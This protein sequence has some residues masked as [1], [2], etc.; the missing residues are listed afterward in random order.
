MPPTTEAR[1]GPA[2]VIAIGLDSADRRLVE[3]WC[4]SG[5]LPALQSMR[6][7][8]AYG[9]LTGFP[10]L[11]DDSTWASFYTSVSPGRHRRYFWQF[12]DEGAYDGRP[13]RY[14][15]LPVEPFWAVLSQ[16]GRR[17]AVLD[18]PKCPL[19]T[20]LNGIQIA[21]WLVHGRDYP[22]TCCWP[23][24]LAEALLSRFGDD[25]TDRA[26]TDDWLCWM[27]SLPESTDPVTLGS[28]AWLKNCLH[29]TSTW[30][31]MLHRSRPWYRKS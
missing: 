21:D 29:T 2:K 28:Q 27:H 19:T 14:Q 23:P 3:R 6:D 18:V 25:Q 11:G 4:D 17:A 15:T 7:R 12:L 16:S 22:E 5:Y 30:E 13:R 10:A 24:E 8:G 20:G 31:P 26:G 1:V 9:H